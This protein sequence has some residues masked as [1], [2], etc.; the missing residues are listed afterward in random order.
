MLEAYKH[1]VSLFCTLTY[2]DEHLPCDGSVSLRDVQL[3]MKLLRYRMAMLVPPRK[4]RYYL[5]AEYGDVGDRPHYHAVLFGM[6]R[7][8]HIGLKLKGQCGCAV[9]QSWEHGGVHIGFLTPLSAGYTVSYMLKEA[10]VLPGRRPEFAIMSRRP[11][12]IGASAV[13]EIADAH[14]TKDGEILL[15]E[16]DVGTVYRADKKK[17]PLGRYLRQKVRDQ[18]GGDKDRARWR[19][20][21]ELRAKLLSKEGRAKHDRARQAAAAQAEFRVK[22]I[23]GKKT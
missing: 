7:M 17:W 22:F 6:E 10:R 18:I 23:G 3:F 14:I 2:D 21:Q 19:M 11:H 4:V 13:G 16:G 9:C 15:P 20:I 8:D 12:G 1:E 5:V